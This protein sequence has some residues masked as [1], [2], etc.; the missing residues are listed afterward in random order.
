MTHPLNSLNRTTRYLVNH[1]TFSVKHL[2]NLQRLLADIQVHL[3]KSCKVA[4]YL[5]IYY[6]RK[7][8]WLESRN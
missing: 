1:L 8:L 7:Y 5:A 6:S 4:V 2:K 3:R